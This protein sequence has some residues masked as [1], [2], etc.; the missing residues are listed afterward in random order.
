[1]LKQANN[2]FFVGIKGVA[3]ANWAIMLNKMGN[4]VNGADRE[5]EFITDQ[6]LQNNHI[7]R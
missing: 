7:K 3:M 1:M 6:I 5:E 2:I 4:N